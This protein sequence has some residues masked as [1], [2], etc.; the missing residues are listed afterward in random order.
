MGKVETHETRSVDRSDTNPKSILIVDDEPEVVTALTDLLEDQFNVVGRT[1]ASEGLRALEHDP[2]IAVVISDQRMP[3][4]SGDKFLANVK[5]ISYATRVLIT[6][7]ADLDAVVRAVNDG[8]IFAYI[9]K[10]WSPSSISMTVVRAVEQYEL[11]NELARERALMR[12]LMTNH[13]DAIFFKDLEHRFTRI[14][15]PVLNL[16]DAASEEEVVGKSNS[17]L[18]TPDRA[19]R[20]NDEERRVVETGE[21]L[22]D[23]VESFAGAKGQQFWFSSTKALV[24]D[25]EGRPTGFVGMTRDIT[26]RVMAERQ[27]DILLD[28]SK[29]L[30][31]VSDFDAAVDAVLNSICEATNVP[32]AEAWILSAEGDAFST[33]SAHYAKTEAAK[34]FWDHTQSV[35][36]QAGR[37]LPG[38]VHES[39]SSMLIPDIAAADTSQFIRKD[40][41]IRFGFQSCLGIPVHGR[42]NSAL[43]VLIFFADAF[44]DKQQVALLEAIGRQLGVYLE[45]KLD[46]GRLR[47]SEHDLRAVLDT[48]TELITR[49][50]QDGTRLFASPAFERFLNKSN[51]EVLKT[52]P[53]DLVSPEIHDQL[54][55]ELYDLTPEIPERTLAVPMRRHDGELRWIDWRARG[56]FDDEGRLS[57]IQASGRDI[58]EKVE[59]ETKARL[60]HQILLDAINAL[61]VGFALFD[62]DDRLLV[63]N[64]LYRT[65]RPSHLHCHVVKGMSAENIIRRMAE[66]GMYEE[67]GGDV[68]VQVS[69]RLQLWSKRPNHYEI[70]YADGRWR[71]FR[72]VPATNGGTVLLR[73]DITTKK[74]NERALAHSEALFRDFA[75]IASDWMWEADSK[76]RLLEAFGNAKSPESLDLTR[77]IDAWRKEY[78]SQHP[79]ALDVGPEAASDVALDRLELTIPQKGKE[80]RIYAVNAKRHYDEDQDDNRYRGTISD[81]TARRRAERQVRESETKLRSILDNADDTI[82]LHDSDGRIIEVN[83]AAT[84]NLGYSRDELLSMTVFEIEIA[85]SETDL[86]KLFPKDQPRRVISGRHRRKDTSEF[87]VEVHA[88]RVANGNNQLFVAIAR[89]MTAWEDLLAEL[90]RNSERFRVLITHSS[91]GILVHRDFKPLYANPALARMLGYASPDEL[92]ALESFEA[93]FHPEELDRIRTYSQRRMREESVP[94][95][96]ELRCRKKDGTTIFVENRAALLPWEDGEAICA[97]LV[98]ITEQ[99]A[100][101]ERL[102]QAQKM[103]AVGQLTGGIAHDFNNLL[104]VILGNLNLL[105]NRVEHLD[106]PK[107]VK[108]ARNARHSAQRGADLTKRLLAFSRRQ[109]LEPT[110]FEVNETINGMADMF[111]RVIDANVSLK[112]DTQK[113]PYFIRADPS[114]FEN[115]LL[116]LTV[117]ARDAMPEGGQLTIDARSITLRES[118][119]KIWEEG[120]PGDYIQIS[121]SDSGQGMPE[122]VRK[123][124]FEPFFTT[125]AVGKGTGLGLSMVFGFVKQSGGHVTIYSEVGHGTTVRLYFPAVQELGIAPKDTAIDAEISFEGLTVL[126]A[127]DDAAVRETAEDM[128]VRL[129]F[130]VVSS[131]TGPQALEALK[132][133]P[134]IDILFTDIVMPGGMNG[135]ELAEKAR[136]AAPRLGVLFTSGYAE[137]AIRE[138]GHNREGHWLSKPYSIERLAEKLTEVI[139][140]REPEND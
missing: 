113:D 13:P 46:E 93:I 21:P 122:E 127:E 58:T 98:D 97:N 99:K 139:R 56:I 140:K 110:E 51:D 101:E 103:E 55:T 67:F 62:K 18:M 119:A 28:I 30:V 3:E 107:L 31:D 6:G 29:Q 60:S 84:R 85:H 111:E 14:N 116:N 66:A 64:E 5:E 135:L 130:K 86:Q 1:S 138:T 48:Q 80:P 22:R 78:A 42:S 11:N 133:N 65:D 34:K 108:W 92:M 88:A 131:E 32:Y 89:D 61:P 70:K 25:T 45:A 35:K 118:D 9:S 8:K 96:Y 82:F 137:A 74:S 43:A 52:T 23:R 91:Q 4:M 105:I 69:R 39:V 134:D 87:P 41:A 38:A 128:L 10:P 73:N 132:E 117:N 112:I 24:R 49:V 7:F 20:Q 63:F 57:E 75:E 123:K 95:N 71:E 15:R 121:V 102:H 109:I 79:G 115:A 120:A 54:R 136:L 26:S 53:F 81:I 12:D 47:E 114:Q 44:N 16:L 76:G 126:L 37:G 100:I 124:V 72:Q 27:R 2:S 129:G 36:I 104:T 77:I 83:N 125:K 94:Q 68:E 33:I 59:A 17:D 50:K 40:M 106:Q 19:K 90:R